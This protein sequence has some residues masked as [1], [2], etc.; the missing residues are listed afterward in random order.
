MKRTAFI[1]ITQFT[2]FYAIVRF[3]LLVFLF[4][5]IL[6][7]HSRLYSLPVGSPGWGSLQAEIFEEILE[8]NLTYCFLFL[9]F[10]LLLHGWKG[11]KSHLR[12]VGKQFLH[13]RSY[14]QQCLLLAQQH[15][16]TKFRWFAVPVLG[17][18]GFFF[19]IVL[20]LWVY[21]SIWILTLG[22]VGECIA[23]QWQSSRQQQLRYMYENDTAHVYPPKVVNMLIFLAFYTIPL[24]IH[25]LFGE[26][27]SLGFWFRLVQVI[28]PFIVFPYWLHLLLGKFPVI[29]ESRF[30]VGLYDELGDSPSPFVKTT[31]SKI[32]AFLF[33]AFIMICLL[34][35]V[36]NFIYNLLRW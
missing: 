1:K 14:R 12:H 2:L 33:F 22:I 9:L 23:M 5:T 7:F 17:I 35:K 10:R 6:L 28:G 21:P 32:F 4:Q 18:F 29:T 24:H 30:H 34:V 16:I 26:T 3:S 13:L 19:S 31:R 15:S 11:F 25:H 36:I 20:F 27:G 8:Y